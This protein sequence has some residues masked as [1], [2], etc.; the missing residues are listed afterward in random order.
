MANP[1]IQEYVKSVPARCGYP[2]EVKFID[3]QPLPATGK[4]RRYRL[5]EI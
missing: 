1:E 5:A 4:I 3:E 2:R